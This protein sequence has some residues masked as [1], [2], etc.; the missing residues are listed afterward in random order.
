M[1]CPR[2]C[3]CVVRHRH[4]SQVSSINA[5]PQAGDR[6]RVAGL[7]RHQKT[8]ANSAAHP[9]PRLSCS[10][11]TCAHMQGTRRT[12]SSPRRR[13]AAAA[14]K[15]R[16]RGARTRR[17]LH[18]PWTALWRPARLWGRRPGVGACSGGGSPE[19]LGGGRREEGLPLGARLSLT[20]PPAPTAHLPYLDVGLAHDAHV[21]Q[22]CVG[23]AARA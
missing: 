16:A 15:I 18:P 3:C 17:T 6:G 21:L 14:C 5:G 11:S 23:G 4:D 13:T 7:P 1:K 12:R 10:G 8:K 19:E 22:V 9:S 20:R 2:R